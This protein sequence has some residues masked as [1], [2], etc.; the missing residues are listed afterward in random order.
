MVNPQEERKEMW[1]AMM[2]ESLHRAVIQILV[3]EGWRK[4]T[5]ERVTQAAGMAKGTLYNYFKD[6]DD[7]LRY[8]VRSSLDP[9]DKEIDKILGSGA[10]PDQRLRDVVLCVLKYF[11]ENRAFFR[12]L[13]DPELSGPRMHPKGRD[14]QQVLI[15]KISRVY[16]EGVKQVMFRPLPPE[17]AAAMFVMSSVALVMERM[18]RDENTPIEEEAALHADFFLHGV[19]VGSK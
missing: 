3:E 10:A 5:M 2:K 11:D 15:L 13:L 9:L 7:L 1:H 12:V 16:D 6:K 19:A 4:L 18:M 8:A 17:K 14:R